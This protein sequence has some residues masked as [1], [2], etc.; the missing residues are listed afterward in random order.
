MSDPC[1]HEHDWGVMEEW[2]KETSQK[3]D[4]ILE[5]AIKTNGRLKALEHWRTVLTTC[6]VTLLLSNS[7]S[8]AEWAKAL[9]DWL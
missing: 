1:Q 8:L 7:G 5:Q 3:L 6:V 2:R 4:L 9:K